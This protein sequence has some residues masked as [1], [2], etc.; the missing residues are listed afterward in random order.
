MNVSHSNSKTS[1]NSNLQI[2]ISESRGAVRLFD[3]S[4]NKVT[5]NNTFHLNKVFPF[6]M[7]TIEVSYSR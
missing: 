3:N 1:Q 5:D 2:S 6:D 4:L 7:I